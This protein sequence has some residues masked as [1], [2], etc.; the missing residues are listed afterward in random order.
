MEVGGWLEMLV[1]G[2]TADTDEGMVAGEREDDRAGN[3]ER[4]G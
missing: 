1:V 2:G 4:P 3:G